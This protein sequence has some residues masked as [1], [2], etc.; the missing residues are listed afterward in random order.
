[1]IRTLQR[2]IAKTSAL[3]YFES[4]LVK[5]ESTRAVHLHQLRTRLH[6]LMRTVQNNTTRCADR[7]Y[8]PKTYG[9]NSSARIQARYIT[10]TSRAEA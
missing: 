5:S 3:K 7:A 8:T 1:M 4:A 10:S 6:K 2:D 9:H